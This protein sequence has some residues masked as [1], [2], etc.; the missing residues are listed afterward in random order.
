MYAYHKTEYLGAAHGL[1]GILQVILSF[2]E[3]LSVRHESNKLVKDSVDY[4]LTTKKSNGNFPT[5]TNSAAN[6]EQKDL[7]H[8]CHGAAGT[9]HLLARAYMVW[10]DPMYLKAAVE[11]GEVIWERGLLKKGPGICH[12][13][14]GNGYAHL[15]LYRL[16]G[17]GKYLNR[18]WYFA[19]FMLSD[20][21]KNE[22]RLPD[23]PFSLFEGLC[24]TVCFISDL[25]SAPDLAEFPVFPIFL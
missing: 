21:F 20:H 11:C 8:W 3:Y 16:T 9:I 4:I 5:S 7:V 12:G 19:E 17:D 1:S 6:D 2:P 14:A 25:I 10:S 24:G 15:V 22:A 13:I 18:A 23:R